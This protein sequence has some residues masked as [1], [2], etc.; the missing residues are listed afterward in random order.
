MV[1]LGKLLR[2]T[3]HSDYLAQ[4]YG[5]GEI[6]Q[7]PAPA[8]Y[9]LGTFV[10][11][12]LVTTPASWLVGVIGD[13]LLFNPDFGR[14]GPRLTAGADLPFFSPD[15]VNEKAVL[16][17]VLAVGTLDAEGRADQ[18]LPA[19]AALTDVEIEPLSEE[20]LLAFHTASAGL[21]LAYAARL[22]ALDS[23]LAVTLLRLI[24]ARLRQL[25]FAAT[26]L[27]LLDLLHNQL[28]WQQQIRPFGGEG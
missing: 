10:Q 3:G 1:P 21:H 19:L 7:P 23:P 4:I 20:R 6:D 9:A 5:P 22:L 26:D 25:P 11:I 18:A 13:T 24:L 2:S 12:P 15:Y 16:V 8:D 14:L 28:T 17:A 27:A